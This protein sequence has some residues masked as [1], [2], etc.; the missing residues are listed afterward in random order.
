[1]S[2]KKDWVRADARAISYINK[3]MQRREEVFAIFDQTRRVKIKKTGK[4]PGFV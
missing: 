3:Y 2:V 1:M 4:I